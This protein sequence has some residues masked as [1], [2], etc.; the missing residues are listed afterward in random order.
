MQIGAT[1]HTAGLD[2]GQR[3][4]LASF[5]TNFDNFLK[6]L[7]QQL[8]HQDPLAPL[9]ANQFTAQLVQFTA[10]EQAIKTNGKLDQL[11]AL[12]SGDHSTAALAYIGKM[13]E[14]VGDRLQLGDTGAGFSY[15]LGDGASATAMVI[16]DSL[17]QPAW[18]GTGEVTAGPHSYHWD[19]TDNDGAALPPGTYSIQV[20]AVDKDGKPVKV[21]TTTFAQV[22]GVEI[23][24]GQ[25]FLD[26]GGIEIPA[27]S[28]RAIRA[29]VVE[30]AS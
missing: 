22:V 13:V 19:G 2:S 12:Q 6:L 4:S 3:S 17:G 11:I 27:S 15:D 26:L 23:R 9:D 29:P 25:T 18:T 21:S 10:V 1:S 16:L 24:D 8:Q 30:A 7:T 5:S 20:A 14:A 28:V